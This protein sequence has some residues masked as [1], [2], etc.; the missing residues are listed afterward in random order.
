MTKTLFHPMELISTFSIYSVCI[1]Y[2]KYE[3][4]NV[5][6]VVAIWVIDIGYTRKTNRAIRIGSIHGYAM[7][8]DSK[9]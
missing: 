1:L 4:C 2:F 5:F 9:T 6:I 7:E 3:S 8:V